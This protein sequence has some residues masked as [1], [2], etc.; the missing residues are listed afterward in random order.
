MLLQRI[1][2]SSID[3]PASKVNARVGSVGNGYWHQPASTEGTRT[4]GGS[5]GE[6]KLLFTLALC[7]TI[8]RSEDGGLGKAWDLLF[9]AWILA[10]PRRG[11]LYGLAAGL[12]HIHGSLQR[13]A[14]EQMVILDSSEKRTYHGDIAG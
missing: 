12:Y 3:F 7:A 9:C 2:R 1:G 14:K 11:G 5:L 8:N 4:Q 6:G 10:Y 13:E